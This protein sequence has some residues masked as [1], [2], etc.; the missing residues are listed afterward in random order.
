MSTI[1]EKTVCWLLDVVVNS[2]EPLD[3]LL[4]VEEA[5]EDYFA[6]AFNRRSHGMTFP[7]LSDTLWELFQQR[8]IMTWHLIDDIGAEQTDS[9]TPSR[10]QIDNALLRRKVTGSSASDG[11]SPRLWYGLTGE[12]GSQW[13]FLTRPDWNRYMVGIEAFG[14]T[15][16]EAFSPLYVDADEDSFD[17]SAVSDLPIESK[18]GERLYVQLSSINTQLLDEYLD[19]DMSEYRVVDT[20]SIRREILTPWH[21]TYWKTFKSGYQ[22]QYSLWAERDL[23]EHGAKVRDYDQIRSMTDRLAPSWYTKCPE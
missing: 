10:H 17:D 11:I 15:A 23:L 13:E 9:F 6:V 14:A 16:E 4:P 12:G 8:L 1:S 22:Y 20:A 5:D 3:A 18:R 19:R 21:A 2:R 7:E